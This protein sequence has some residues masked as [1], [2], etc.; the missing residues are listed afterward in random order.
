M[1]WGFGKRF[2]IL[3]FSLSVV[4]YTLQPKDCSPPGFSIHGISQATILEWADISLSRDLPDPGIEPTSLVSPS[5]QVD[6]I[7]AEPLGKPQV[8]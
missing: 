4:S 6:S 5:I 8:Y 3:L 2:T 7:L 1:T